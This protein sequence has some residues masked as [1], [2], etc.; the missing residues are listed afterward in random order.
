M[1]GWLER[2]PCG[3]RALL[4]VLCLLATPR[5]ELEVVVIMMCLCIPC[6]KSVF[7]GRKNLCL[8]A[9]AAHMHSL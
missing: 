9:V 6:L 8:C 1:A 5:A 4:E 7:V 3:A 2:H